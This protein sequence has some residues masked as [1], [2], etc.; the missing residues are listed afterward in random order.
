M[1][2]AI[3]AKSIIPPEAAVAYAHRATVADLTATSTVTAGGFGDLG[4]A[5]RLHFIKA[6]IKIKALSGTLTLA[7]ESADNTGFS[8][9]RR[10]L[11]AKTAI[12]SSVLGQFLL[13]GWTELI[14]NQYYRILFTVGTSGTY[15]AEVHATPII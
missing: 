13:Q 4:V 14:A 6:K 3:V 1:A 2:F 12:T 9:N 7:L 15:D 5:T 8:T 10:Q 11:D